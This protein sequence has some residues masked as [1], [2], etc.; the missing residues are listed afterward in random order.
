MVS[1]INEKKLLE[2]LKG[3]F[4]RR[5]VKDKVTILIPYNQRLRINCSSLRLSHLIT[6]ND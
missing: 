2:E 5:I 6:E 3:N 1:W 4:Q